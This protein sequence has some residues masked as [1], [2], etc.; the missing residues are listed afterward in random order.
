M[1]AV[2]E[3]PSGAWLA[4]PGS[5]GPAPWWMVLVST[6]LNPRGRSKYYT[7]PT[8]RL[9]DPSST[10]PRTDSWANLAAGDNTLPDE[11]FD[12]VTT[13]G[14][15]RLASE[16]DVASGVGKHR[17]G[18]YLNHRTAMLQRLADPDL[19]YHPVYNPYITIDWMPMDL[20][21]FNGEDS[22]GTITDETAPAA[23]NAYAFSLDIRMVRG[24]LTLQQLQLA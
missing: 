22:A 20:T 7:L 10:Y 8:L 6:S 18:T 21:V 24:L 11:P 16:I 15:E 23:A 17:R 1:V 19:P 14:L 12:Y 5:G 4:A 9:L 13:P 2:T 3:P